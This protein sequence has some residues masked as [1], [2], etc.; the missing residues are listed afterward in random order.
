MRLFSGGTGRSSLAWARKVGGVFTVTCFS[1]D[2]KSIIFSS[3]SLPNNARRVMRFVSGNV[4]VTNSIPQD[5][6]KVSK[7]VVQ[8]SVARLLG[9]AIARIHDDCSV[10][11]LF[12]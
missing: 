4:I 11:E 1:A 9:E 7:K 6:S 3:A 10:S 5:S 8:L 2:S 12:E